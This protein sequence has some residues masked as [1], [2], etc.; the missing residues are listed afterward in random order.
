MRKKKVKGVVS[1]WKLK[2]GEKAKMYF[3]KTPEQALEW[4]KRILVEAGEIEPTDELEL[5]RVYR[6]SNDNYYKARPHYD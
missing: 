4:L 5:E 1:I 3:F 6:D 2:R